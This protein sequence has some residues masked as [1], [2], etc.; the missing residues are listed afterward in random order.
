[1]YI[2]RNQT[3]FVATQTADFQQNGQFA[4]SNIRV[5]YKK[6]RNVVYSRHQTPEGESVA[7]IEIPL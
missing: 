3:N 2:Q 4:L 5:R 1:M 7:E 6:V